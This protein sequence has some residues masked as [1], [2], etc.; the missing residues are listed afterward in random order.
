MKGP[1]VFVLGAGASKPYGYPLGKDLVWHIAADSL[2]AESCLDKPPHLHHYRVFRDNL[3]NSKAPSVDLFL[4]RDS[5]HRFETVGKL[6]IAENLILKEDHSAIFHNQKIDDDWLG[7]LFNTLTAGIRTLADVGKLPISFVTFNY[8]R[9]LEHFLLNYLT[10]NF[11]DN[12]TGEVAA[13]IA[14]IPIIHVYGWLGPLDWQHTVGARAY[15]PTI[16]MDIVRN[17]ADRITIMHEGKDQSD[18]FERVHNLFSIA[19]SIWLLGFGYHPENMRRLRLPFER[20]TQPNPVTGRN[21]F[22]IVG[23]AYGLTPAEADGVIKQSGCEN[24]QLWNVNH[25]ITD[26]LRNHSGFLSLVR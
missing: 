15:S 16:N 2:P 18:E 12:N 6:A 3:A 5:Q 23:T 26:T 10:S 22:S 17:A 7:Y 25:K 19:Q 21:E 9:V 1:M 11:P 4:G 20:L 8:D 24:W 14:K 13:V